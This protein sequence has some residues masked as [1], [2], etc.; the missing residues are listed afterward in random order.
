L[1]YSNRARTN[2]PPTT[3]FSVL[4]AQHLQVVP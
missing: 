1:T 3:L 2:H 4:E